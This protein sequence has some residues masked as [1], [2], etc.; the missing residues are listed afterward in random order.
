MYLV[1]RTQGL[2]SLSIVGF[3]LG[4]KS[5]LFSV[6]PHYLWVT[7]G[8]RKRRPKRKPGKKRPAASCSSIQDLRSGSS[9]KTW[10]RSKTNRK[11]KTLD[12][13]RDGFLGQS[14]VFV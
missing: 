3:T 7:S 11:S 14:R 5:S 9:P 6:P 8:K 13:F 4:A 2:P 10:N 1:S 12:I